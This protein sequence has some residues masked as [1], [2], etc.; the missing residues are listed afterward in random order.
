MDKK[1]YEKLVE[2]VLE[3]DVLYYSKSQPIITD[4]AYDQLLKKL[5]EIEKEHPEWISPDS[6]TKR[7]QETITESFQQVEHRVPMLSL[8]NTYSKEELED[9][10]QRAVKGLDGKSPTFCSELKMDGIAVS[11]LFEKGRFVRGMTRGNG[12]KG[13]DITANMR[14]IRSIPLKLN[15]KNPPDLLEVKIGRAHV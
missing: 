13:D 4:Y 7:V 3:H 2:E 9:F 14:T 6:P 8:S 12:K 10:I 11:C 5:E 15:T 1:Q